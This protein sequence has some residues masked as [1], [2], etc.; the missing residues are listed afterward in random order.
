MVRLLHLYNRMM[1]PVGFPSTSGYLFSFL[2]ALF[3]SCIMFLVI[4]LFNVGFVGDLGYVWLKAWLFA[5]VLAFPVITLVA[6]VVRR[7]V[8]MATYVEQTHGQ[9]VGRR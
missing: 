6:P 8:A 9:S 1:P 7:M 3:M 4:T 5:F 2:M